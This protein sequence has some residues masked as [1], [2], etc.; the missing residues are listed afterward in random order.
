MVKTDH[1]GG[2]ILMIYFLNEHHCFFLARKQTEGRRREDS[3]GGGGGRGARTDTGLNTGTP[4][5]S[6]AETIIRPTGKILFEYPLLLTL[7]TDL[8]KVNSF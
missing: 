8:E 1:L 3:W 6:T 4:G 7:E 5:L 2:G